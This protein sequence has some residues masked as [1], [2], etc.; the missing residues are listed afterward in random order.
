MM[1]YMDMGRWSEKCGQEDKKT[2]RDMAGK[3]QQH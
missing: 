3:E 2:H 1:N